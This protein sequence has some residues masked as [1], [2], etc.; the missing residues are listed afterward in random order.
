MFDYEWESMIQLGSV[1]ATTSSSDTVDLD[2]LAYFY[3]VEAG[4]SFKV[5]WSPRI[6]LE[7]DFASGDDDPNDERNE[8]FERFFG[9]NGPEFEPV[10]IHAAFVRANISS[11]GVRVQIQPSPDI[12]NSISYRAYW[13]ASE[14]DG[15]QGA[16]GL[17]DPSGSS[18][19][20]LGQLLIL[21]NKW[22]LFPNF[23][24]EGGVTYRIDGGF[25]NKVTGS[26]R[27]GNTIYSYIQTSFLF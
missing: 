7:Y 22:K 19:S 10:S 24:I 6:Y 14:K 18:G 12:F 17:R 15:W 8:R 9:P 23:R 11:P 1:R 13:L 5:L 2:L 3:H 27:V 16:S 26:P 4:Y 20:F 25:Q 21:K